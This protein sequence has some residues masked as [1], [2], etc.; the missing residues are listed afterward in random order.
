MAGALAGALVHLIIAVV[1]LYTVDPSPSIADVVALTATSCG[2]GGPECDRLEED[3]TS[4]L[5]RFGPYKLLSLVLNP[6]SL[7]V[8]GWTRSGGILY[9]VPGSL[10]FAG[11][12]AV[13]ANERVPRIRRLLLLVGVGAAWLT[14]AFVSTLFFWFVFRMCC[15][16]WGV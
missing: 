1:A 9:Y 5:G 8:A 11:V 6:L 7:G 13:S 3:A 14:L 12:G 10:L 16:E 15:A 4:F 2:S